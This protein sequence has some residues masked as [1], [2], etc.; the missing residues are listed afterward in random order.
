[1]GELLYIVSYIQTLRQQVTLRQH[2]ESG[3]SSAMKDEI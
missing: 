1:M 2:V 3:G